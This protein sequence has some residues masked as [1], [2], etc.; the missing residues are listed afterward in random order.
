MGIWARNVETDP[1]TLVSEKTN[2]SY[3]LLQI[4][5]NSICLL[6]LIIHTEKEPFIHEKLSDF[7]WNRADNRLPH[8]Q[9]VCIFPALSDITTK[10]CNLPAN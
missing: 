1:G 8:R 4:L 5:V 2:V 10:V 7:D 3:E 6:P 9:H